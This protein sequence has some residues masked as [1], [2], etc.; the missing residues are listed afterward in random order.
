MSK[1]NILLIGRTGNGK[2]AL[3]NVLSGTDKFK[4]S[5]SSVSEKRKIQE[6][7]FEYKGFKY[8]VID[9][10]GI[11]DTKLT[12][13][14]VLI[15]VAEA[16]GKVSKGLNQVLFVT[17]GKFTEEEFEAYNL[18]RSIIFD[19]DITN[20]TTIV[21][22]GF[23]DFEDEEKCAEETRNL[24][25]ENPKMAELFKSCNK[26]IYV[27]N[28]AVP[29]KARSSA[30]AL[31]KEIR[32]ESRK[33]ILEHLVHNCANY[34]PVSLSELDERIKSYMTEKEQLRK[35]LEELMKI[36]EEERKIS[37]E[38]LAELDAERKRT[39]RDNEEERKKLPRK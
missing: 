13:Q 31:A 12:P 35:E 8:C 22:T 17:R 19:K 28:P 6:K 32:E 16:C 4:E 23:V 29:V 37:A 30:I 21:R 11:G 10:I 36:N 24:N 39:A 15:I 34:Q 18:L 26:V 33:K 20:Y 1:R 25:E 14:E 3:A 38:K 9:T 7:E 2:S 5:Q 27:D